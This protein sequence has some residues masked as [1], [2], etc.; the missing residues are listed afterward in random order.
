MFALDIVDCS[1]I[2]PIS[3]KAKTV[4]DDNPSEFVGGGG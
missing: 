2:C 1:M 3:A 4:D